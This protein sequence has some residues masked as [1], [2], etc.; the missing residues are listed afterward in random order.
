[1]KNFIKKIIDYLLKKLIHRAYP[2]FK[3]QVGYTSYTTVF[4]RYFVMQ[5]IIGI[6]RKVPWPVHFT[7]VIRDWEKIEKGICC[8]P[9]DNN[10]IYINAYGGLKLGNNVNIGSNSSIM[11]SNHYKYDH[12]KRGFKQGITIGNNVWIGANCVITAGVTIGD[13]VTIGAGCVI[14]QDIPSNVTVITKSDNLDLIPKRAYE[15]DCTQEELM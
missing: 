1:M 6:N 12:R 10:G 2:Q 3:R 13:N 4:K 14:R 11:T 8:D 15:W 7:S 9:G 5:K